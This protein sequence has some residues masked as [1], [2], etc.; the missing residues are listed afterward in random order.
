MIFGP[1]SIVLGVSFE[2]VRGPQFKLTIW[3]VLK[4]FEKYNTR[5]L[6]FWYSFCLFFRDP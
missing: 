4:R 6:S 5:K 3:L 1:T 2:V